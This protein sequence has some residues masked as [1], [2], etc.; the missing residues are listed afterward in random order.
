MSEEKRVNAVELGMETLDNVDGG[1]AIDYLV[2][3]NKKHQ[4][5]KKM[6]K[7]ARSYTVKSAIATGE[8]IAV[9]MN[10]DEEEQK[11]KKRIP[12]I[13]FRDSGTAI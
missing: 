9:P 10:T 5:V 12:K 11:E 3:N 13:V 1:L 6:P 7:E 8:T 4:Q 2:Q